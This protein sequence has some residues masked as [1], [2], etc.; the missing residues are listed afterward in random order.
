[1][2]KENKQGIIL[3]TDSGFDFWDPPTSTTAGDVQKLHVLGNSLILQSLLHFPLGTGWGPAPGISSNVTITR[4]WEKA[5]ERVFN[6]HR[7]LE[8]TP[9]SGRQHTPSQPNR[10]TYIWRGRVNPVPAG[11]IMPESSSQLAKRWV[12]SGRQTQPSS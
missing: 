10:L 2:K 12:L 4:V 8:Q 1:M 6:N 9:A 5:E 11:L 3:S 7:G